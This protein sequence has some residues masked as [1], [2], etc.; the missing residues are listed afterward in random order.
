MYTKTKRRDNK[1]NRHIS[2]LFCAV[3]DSWGRTHSCYNLDFYKLGQRRHGEDCL[4]YDMHVNA[5]SQTWLYL[6]DDLSTSYERA[7]RR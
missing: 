7:Y 5:N 1:L 4:W 6:A 2:F 3:L